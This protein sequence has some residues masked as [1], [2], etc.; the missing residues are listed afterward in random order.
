MS[1]AAMHTSGGAILLEWVRDMSRWIK[2]NDSN[3]L[4]GVG[5]EGFWGNTA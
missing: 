3:H 4:L 2:Q 5:D 1:R